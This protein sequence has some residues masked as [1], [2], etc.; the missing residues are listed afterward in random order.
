M[1]GIDSAAEN[2]YL[3]SGTG[4]PSAIALALGAHSSPATI[5]P[6]ALTSA[7]PSLDARLVM[8]MLTSP[9]ERCIDR[10]HDR[11]E[12]QPR[13]QTRGPRAMMTMVQVPAAESIWYA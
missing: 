7:T 13:A 8:V 10:R 2:V 11:Q 12:A 1:S 5:T 3:P 9:R 6:T 4:C